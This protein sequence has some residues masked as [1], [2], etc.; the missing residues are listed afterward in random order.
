MNNAPKQIIFFDGVCHLC[1]G[2]VDFVI[3]RDKKRQFLY[4][5]IQGPTYSKLLNRANTPEAIF[6]WQDGKISERSTAVLKILSQ[7]PGPWKL[8]AVFFIIPR[9]IRDL[10]YNYIAAKRYLW[11]GKSETCRIPTANERT[12]FLD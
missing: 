2:F 4:A 12:L 10:I 9:F 5:P 11:F 7:L 6:F 1:N 8:S 3:L